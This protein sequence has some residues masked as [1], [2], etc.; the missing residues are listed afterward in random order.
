M[1]SI[2]LELKI[3]RFVN[4]KV[5]RNDLGA[6]GPFYTSVPNYHA[7]EQPTALAQQS[8][9]VMIGSA[10][11]NISMLFSEFRM[12]YV[13]IVAGTHHPKVLWTNI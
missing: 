5:V 9:N 6:R 10:G 11:S 1:F 4:M 7:M 2:I 3:N 12:V 8:C 13:P